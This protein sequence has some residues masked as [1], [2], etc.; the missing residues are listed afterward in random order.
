MIKLEFHK[1]DYRVSDFRNQ[2]LKAEENNHGS[3]SLDTNRSM[4]LSSDMT[5]D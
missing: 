4:L 5:N 2:N 3:T 1:R